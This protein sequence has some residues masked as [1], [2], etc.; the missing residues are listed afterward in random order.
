MPQEK[1]KVTCHEFVD[2]RY[3]PGGEGAIREGVQGAARLT[4]ALE[5][6]RDLKSGRMPWE[7]VD[8]QHREEMFSQPTAVFGVL[9]RSL[10]FLKPSCHGHILEPMTS[11]PSELPGLGSRRTRKG[12]RERKQTSAGWAN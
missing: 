1:F 2:C 7:M 12:G 4:W 3:L 8:S 5:G 6:K 11:S 10:V 9:H